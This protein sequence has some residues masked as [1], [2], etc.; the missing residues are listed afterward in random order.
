MTHSTS[1]VAG[2]EN[3]I[4]KLAQTD[5][6]RVIGFQ[7]PLSP[8]D[9]D[10]LPLPVT[11]I[12]G[13]EFRC[14]PTSIVTYGDDTMDVE[15][16]AAPFEVGDEDNADAFVEYAGRVA[17]ELGHYSLDETVRVIDSGPV[18]AQAPSAQNS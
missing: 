17:E 7:P 9:L 4:M 2:P 8:D 10:K 1:H 11:N 3:P 15:Y 16:V 5:G 13:I 6:L 18:I 12:G 14:D